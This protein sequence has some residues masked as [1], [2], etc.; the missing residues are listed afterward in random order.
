MRAG[1]QAL[2][3]LST[4]L[5]VHILRALE[6]GPRS[7]IELRRAAELAPPTTV[8]KGLTA[9]AELGVVAR[10][11]ESQFPAA[12]E[13][14][15]ERP[16][17]QL[18]AVAAVVER[19][20]T[21]C[22]EG[23]LALASPA[24]RNA[25]KALMEGWSTLVVRALAAKSL[26][27]T[28]L[29]RLINEVSYPS[30]ER[31]L[32]ALRL[33][34]QVEAAPT[35]SGTPYTVTPWLRHAIAPLAAAIHWELDHPPGAAVPFGRL[36]AEAIFLLLI[37]LVTLADG[38]GGTCRIA[39]ESRGADRESRFAGVTAEWRDGQP[40]AWS[41]RLQGHPEAS[42]TG[43]TAA[44]LRVLS[45]GTAEDLDLSGDSALA[46][47]VMLG[48]VASIFENCLDYERP[49]GESAIR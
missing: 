45:D 20:L 11:R 35:G 8:R 39:I 48:I 31:R 19:W 23:E 46:R 44:W 17:R 37:P 43:S 7:L 2:A 40:V 49:I 33:T 15:L 34:G 21:R 9:L 1:T 29:N 41:S 36:D 12:T 3:L 38:D 16:G 22:P 47:N 4:P 18:L 13:Y 24:A 25:L 5:N 10:R 26:T 42:V 28:E 32:R 6:E 27:L 30:L 14:E